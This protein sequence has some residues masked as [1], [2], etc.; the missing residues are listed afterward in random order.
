ME[1]GTCEA[2]VL[3]V[4]AGDLPGLRHPV[5][6]P[7]HLP[8]DAA[9]CRVYFVGRTIG[10]RRWSAGVVWVKRDLLVELS[11]HVSLGGTSLKAQPKGVMKYYADS[12]A[13]PVGQRRATHFA[14]LTS[15]FTRTLTGR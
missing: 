9:R 13:L 4:E 8:W 12:H 5:R 6:L 15:I 3:Q 7:N 14:T 10:W 11:I 2:I 1:P